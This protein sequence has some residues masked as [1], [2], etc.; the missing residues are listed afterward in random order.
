MKSLLSRAICGCP[1]PYGRRF[2]KAHLNL[3]VSFGGAFPI[4]RQADK[5][6]FPLAYEEK[7]T[8]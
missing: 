1:E 6:L 2:R 3:P 8:T 7:T 5:K 4:V